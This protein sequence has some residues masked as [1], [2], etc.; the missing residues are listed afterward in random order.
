MFSKLIENLIVFADKIKVFRCRKR[1]KIES[2]LDALSFG[3]NTN[4]VGALEVAFDLSKYY[5]KIIVVSDLKH[6]VSNKQLLVDTVH[7]MLS[8]RR[9]LVFILVGDYDR[10]TSGILSDIGAKVILPDDIK[11]LK[12]VLYKE[13]LS[14]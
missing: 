1:C 4:L 9:K 6:N 2:I 5:R 8:K 10:R 14:R 12:R 3:G 13:L 7:E 11:N